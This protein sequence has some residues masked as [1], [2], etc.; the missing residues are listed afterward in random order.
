[1][2]KL[3]KYYIE[4]GI[5]RRTAYYY[6]K[7]NIIPDILKSKKSDCMSLGNDNENNVQ[8]KQLNHR[9]N[10]LE[11]KLKNELVEIKVENLCLKM[12]LK[13]LKYKKED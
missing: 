4:S 2:N 12:E 1:M 6:V 7:N 3:V 11:N 5:P 8:I 13:M 10:E 9:I